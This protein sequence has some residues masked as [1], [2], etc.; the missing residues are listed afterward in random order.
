MGVWKSKCLPVVVVAVLCATV[1]LV[2][3]TRYSVAEGRDREWTMRYWQFQNDTDEPIE[4]YLKFRTKDCPDCDFHWVPSAPEQAS[5]Y[6]FRFEPGEKAHLAIEGKKIM[7]S[8]GRYWAKSL[9]SNAQWTDHRDKMLW[10][11]KE[12]DQ[13]IRSYRA[14]EMSSWTTFLQK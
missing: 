2:A 5:A 14:S 7:A 8:G 11:V 6:V 9:T 1:T 12:N 3:S 10:L 13:G 4:L